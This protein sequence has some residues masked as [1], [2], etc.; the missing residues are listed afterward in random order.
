MKSAKMVGVNYKDTLRKRKEDIEFAEDCE[1]ALEL[2]RQKFIDAAEKRAIKGV[3]EPIV[4]CGHVV[5][6]KQVYSDSLLGMF[7]KRGKD[8]SF[9]EKQVVKVEGGI[10]IQHELNLDALSKKARRM[11]RQLCEQIELDNAERVLLPSD[12]DGD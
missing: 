3:K 6:H 9:S 11:L 10:P 8:G 2:Y 7:L 1:I 5:T 12:D 4:S